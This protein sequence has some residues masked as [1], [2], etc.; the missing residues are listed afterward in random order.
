MRVTLLLAALAATACGGSSSSAPPPRAAAGTLSDASGVPPAPPPTP[1]ET[2]IEPPPTTP[3]GGAPTAKSTDAGARTQGTSP[4]VVVTRE[5]PGREKTHIAPPPKTPAAP[6]EKKVITSSASGAATQAT[7]TRGTQPAVR[8]SAREH[9]TEMKPLPPAKTTYSGP[10]SGI[11]RWAGLVDKDGE[12]TI[13]GELAST[14]A[15]A[16]AL[17]GVPVVVQVLSKDMVVVQPPSAATRWKRITLRA[18]SLQSS[19][20]LQWTVLP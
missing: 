9:L 19:L 18:R 17:P 20:I 4:Q 3:A 5:Q 16:G 1:P 15:H 12:L 8:E 6:P 7:V 11:I 10:Q 14:G 13:D 2:P